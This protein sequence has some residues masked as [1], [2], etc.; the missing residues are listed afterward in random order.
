MRAHSPGD[1]GRQPKRDIILMSAETCSQFCD[2]LQ[3]QTNQIKNK[4]W[5]LAAFYL[6]NF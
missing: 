5:S 1:K 3:F 6:F 4:G 2:V